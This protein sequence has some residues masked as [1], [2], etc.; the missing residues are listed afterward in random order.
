MGRE[1]AGAGERLGRDD[2]EEVAGNGRGTAALDRPLLADVGRIPG[3][4]TD[5]AGDQPRCSES[6]RGC[7]QSLDVG[8]VVVEAVIVA[9]TAWFG[10]S[11]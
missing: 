1:S 8:V 4:I 2:I 11:S 3:V 9:A 5:S 6:W 7:V 10:T